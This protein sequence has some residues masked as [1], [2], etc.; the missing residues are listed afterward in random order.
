MGGEEGGGGGERREEEGR[1]SGENEMQTEGYIIF[2]KHEQHNLP[3]TVQD[4][5]YRHKT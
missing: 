1:T 3:K 4:L 5:V 2:S